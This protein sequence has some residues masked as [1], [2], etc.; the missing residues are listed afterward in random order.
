MAMQDR[1]EAVQDM[2]WRQGMEINNAR[3]ETEDITEQYWELHDRMQEKQREMEALQT[4]LE[5]ARSH[6]AGLQV[7]VTV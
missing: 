5:A 3:D 1:Q 6:A 4:E 7:S 2:A